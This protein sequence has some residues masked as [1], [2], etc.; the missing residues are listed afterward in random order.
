MPAPPYPVHPEPLQRSWL[1]KHPVWKIPLGALILILLVVSFGGMVMTIITTS[2]RHSDVYKQAVARA[3][4]SLQVREQF[5]EPLQIAWLISGEL[6]VTGST[7]RANLSIPIS[8]PHG[9]G[10]I[11][12][13]AKK[14]GAFWRF[15]YLQVCGSGQS[16]CT[17]LLSVQPPSQR[18][19]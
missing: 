16:T 11:H 4:E 1:E 8:G 12:V 13:V 2:F 19:F 17:D 10:V 6:S 3:S 7:G 14:A 5:G 15:S 18:E 9:R